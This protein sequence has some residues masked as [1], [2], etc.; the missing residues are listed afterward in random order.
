MFSITGQVIN[1]FEAPGRVAN[2]KSG[3]EAQEAKPKVQLLG[4]MPVPGGQTR[5]ELVTL[6]CEDQAVYD[7][8]RGKTISVALGVFAPARG[9]VIYFI[10][11]GAAP[12]LAP[13]PAPAPASAPA[14]A[15]TKDSKPWG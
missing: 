8:F 11:K 14:S 15:P 5:M 1:T 12:M 4:Q 9:Q 2:E 3:L 13:A 10:P 7:A 6:T